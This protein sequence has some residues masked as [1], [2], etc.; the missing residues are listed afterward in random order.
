MWYCARKRTE[1]TRNDNKTAE[2]KPS[3]VKIC[4][5]VNKEKGKYDK[6]RDIK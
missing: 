1:R 3:A 2:A 6:N 5:A 4:V